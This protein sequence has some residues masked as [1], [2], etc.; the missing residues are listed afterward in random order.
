M[1]VLRTS[2]EGVLLLEPE[3]FRDE[4][5]FF[6]E[7]YNRR[8]FAELGISDEFVQDNHSFSVQHTLRGLHYQLNQPQGKLVR[9][10]T[11][12]IL[13]VAVDLR[14]SSPTFGTSESFL[15]SDDNKRMVWIPVGF[16]H[17][18]KVVSET[19]HV[20][21]KTTG[22]YSLRDERTIVWNDPDLK[23]DWKLDAPPVLS[24]KDKLGQRFLGAEVFE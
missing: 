1:K 5:G 3:V 16:G 11:G 15:L 19:A 9:A 7:S 17:G 18:F 8:K 21:Y 24:H 4:R 22:F 10:I 14:R 13:D 20:T 23:I 6:L 2:L 12:T